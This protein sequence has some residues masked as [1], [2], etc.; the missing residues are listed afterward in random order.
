MLITVPVSMLIGLLCA[1]PV[2]NSSSLVKWIVGIIVALASLFISSVLNVLS[3]DP[4][5]QLS[6]E[7]EV[8]IGTWVHG[9]KLAVLGYIGFLQWHSKK[10]AP[11]TTKPSTV[12]A[13]TP[14]LPK[15]AAVQTGGPPTSVPAQKPHAEPTKIEVEAPAPRAET[16]LL[17]KFPKA[18]T[19]IEYLD[20]AKSAWAS[21]LTFPAE[22]QEKFLSAVEADTSTDL[23]ALVQVL[24]AEHETLLAPFESLEHN[25]ALSK[26]REFGKEAEAEYRRVVENLGENLDAKELLAK[27]KCRF[28]RTSS[29]VSPEEEWKRSHIIQKAK[30][31]FEGASDKIQE[32]GIIGNYSYVFFH[33]TVYFSN[34]ELNDFM[35]K[36]ESLSELKSINSIPETSKPIILFH[37]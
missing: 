30:Q 31:R 27:V 4:S 13:S 23:D 18:A 24:T 14:A 11:E 32:I 16:A 36:V 5:L 19:A 9:V 34:R 12:V 6:F 21:I 15:I 33:G 35:F 2:K 17:D 7:Q 28:D 22:Y 3:D 20:P 26:A 37:R 29:V 10:V 8:A 25:E 1:L